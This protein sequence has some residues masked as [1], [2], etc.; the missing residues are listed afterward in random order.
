VPI[1]ELTGI[2]GLDEGIAQELNT[3][4]L[5]YV[6]ERDRQM[7]AKRQELGV[8]DDLAAIEGLSPVMLVDLGEKGIKTLDDLGDLSGDELIE[9]YLPESYLTLDEANAII[10][11]ARAHWFPD[12]DLT[13][14][15]DETGAAGDGETEEEAQ[16]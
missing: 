8:A 6:E 7:E 15:A 5:A 11:A 13:A 4:A 14:E 9:D 1:E 3:R 10:M 2:E 12:E 16:P